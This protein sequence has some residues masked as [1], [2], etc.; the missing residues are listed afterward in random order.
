MHRNRHIYLA[1]P[2][3]GTP[4]EVERRMGIV[5]KASALIRLKGDYVTT[6]LHHHWSFQEEDNGDGE[7][8][9]KYSENLLTG[10]SLLRGLG[11]NVQMW[12]IR[13]DRWDESEGVQCELSLA[14]SLELPYLFV[15]EEDI[16]HGDLMLW[17]K[18]I[19][20]WSR[21]IGDDVE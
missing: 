13:F 6:P 20:D 14:K 4:E 8:W 2:Y 10:L 7:Y 12:I 5:A 17:E 16:E 18:N 21:Y 11:Q 15:R 1:A 9:L 3:R 19:G